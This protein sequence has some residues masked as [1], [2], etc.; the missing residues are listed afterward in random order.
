MKKFTYRQIGEA[1]GFCPYPA[2]KPILKE[3]LLKRTRFIRI[4]A[5]R[6]FGKTYLASYLA[7]YYM[8]LPDKEI[9]IAAPTKQLTSH[10]FENMA[11]WCQKWDKNIKVT[12]YP[13]KELVNNTTGSRVRFVST[14]E[15]KQLLGMGL[16]FL[17]LEEAA[18]IKK[19]IYSAYLRPT[20]SRPNRDGR[21]VAITTPPPSG[22]KKNW[23]YKQ[24]LL[25]DEHNTSFH[26]RANEGAV[27]DEEF[28]IAKQ[29]LPK[30]EFRSQYLAE[31]LEDDSVVF[32]NFRQCIKGEWKSE[33]E[34]LSIYKDRVA[35]H[36]YIIAI[37]LAVIN[38]FTVI[39]VLD[40]MTLEVV[41]M[42]R[43]NDT[44]WLV[45]QPRIMNLYQ[46]YGGDDSV[47]NV[48]V[49][50]T[51]MGIPMVADLIAAGLPVEGY[52]I[53]GT[54][55]HSKENLIRS[56]VVALEKGLM[57]FP[58]DSKIENE[59]ESFERIYSEETGRSKYS[60]PSGEHDDIVIT[61]ALLSVGL[62]EKYEQ[63]E[64]KEKKPSDLQE[65]VWADMKNIKERNERESRT[66]HE[67]KL[68]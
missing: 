54:G 48:R 15:P 12:E 10:V 2:Q 67:P 25:G 55:K 1:V 46:K 65:K 14:D 21:M 7:F 17:L 61:L 27:T 28:S 18:Q 66:V 9:C 11:P 35:G 51:G 41:A 31:F 29:E 8:M 37:D 33:S 36:E 38:D 26:F 40:M 59:L 50:E 68:W 64:T 49:D 13:N 44:E 60:A 53:T 43:F 62:R 23:F 20:L 58:E 39:M 6:G 63:E 34:G 42:D 32:R 52:K 22:S 5:G 16:D 45:Q 30:D 47:I 56:L 57:T 19:G 4:L 24:Y 3:F